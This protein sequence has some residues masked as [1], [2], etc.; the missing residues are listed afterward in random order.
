[1]YGINLAAKIVFWGKGGKGKGW[2]GQARKGKS[3]N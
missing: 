1:M 3:G 2:K